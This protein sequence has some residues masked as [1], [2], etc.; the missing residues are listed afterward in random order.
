MKMIL[1]IER[2]F[3]RINGLFDHLGNWV[4]NIFFGPLGTELTYRRGLV[5]T[6]FFLSA[7]MIAITSSPFLILIG[8]F[9]LLLSIFF[10]IVIIFSWTIDPLIDYKVRIH[11]IKRWGEKLLVYLTG[12][13]KD[14]EERH[15]LEAYAWGK[16]AYFQELKNEVISFS[17]I[18]LLRKFLGRFFST[19]LIL[20]FGFAAVYFGLH[21][22]NPMSFMSLASQQGL[23]DLSSYGDFV[24]YSAITIA[25]V[26]YGDIYPVHYLARAFAMLE[27]LCGALIVIFL[28][29]SFT[30]ISI[31]L[32]SERQQTLIGEIEDEI[33]EIDKLF[34]KLAERSKES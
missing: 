30:S 10:R 8:I 16:L 9:L 24:Y 32:T 22:I 7:A 17:K 34:A 3:E 25:T 2:L 4:K 27:I 23:N 20:I 29:S 28:I 1:Q 31:H 12:E 26:G 15:H 19:F 5:I 14:L 6:L 33:K 11:K 18:D 21:K 13:F